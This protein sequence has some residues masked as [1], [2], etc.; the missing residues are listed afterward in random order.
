MPKFKVTITDEFHYEFVFETDNQKEVFKIVKQWI[1][2]NDETPIYNI[3]IEIN[4]EYFC[5]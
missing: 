4:D 3:N 1:S 5:P 2:H